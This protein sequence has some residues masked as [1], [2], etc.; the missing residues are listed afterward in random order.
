MMGG[1]TRPYGSRPA[2]RP[3]EMDKRLGTLWAEAPWQSSYRQCQMEERPGR[4][5]AFLIPRWSR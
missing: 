4:K 5:A 2:G 1:V 3:L